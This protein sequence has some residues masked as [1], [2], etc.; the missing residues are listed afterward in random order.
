MAI[1]NLVVLRTAPSL[2]YYL[3]LGSPQ[4]GTEGVN[5][6]RLLDQSNFCEGYGLGASNR[7]ESAQDSLPREAGRLSASI[8]VGD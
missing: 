8:P 1:Q 3:Q 5:R 2:L 6:M 4:T 7:Q